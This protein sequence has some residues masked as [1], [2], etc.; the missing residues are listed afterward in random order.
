M[1]FLVVARDIE[2]AGSCR[3]DNGVFGWDRWDRPL[4]LAMF[5]KTNSITVNCL[6]PQSHT[7]Y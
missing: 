2:S 1:V 4:D 6:P 5:N 3:V 7:Q